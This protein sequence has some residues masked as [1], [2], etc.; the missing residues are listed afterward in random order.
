MKKGFYYVNTKWFERCYYVS[1]TEKGNKMIDIRT[2]NAGVSVNTND[3]SWLEM[4]AWCL[5]P[6][7]EMNKF[8]YSKDNPTKISF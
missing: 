3:K 5:P 4:D 1:G 6:V 7:P 8:E 2:V